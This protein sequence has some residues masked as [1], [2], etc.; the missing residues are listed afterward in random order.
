M[1]SNVATV[2]QDPGDELL[3]ACSAGSLDQVQTLLSGPSMIKT[4]LSYQKRP[5]HD[6]YELMRS[7]LNLQVMLERAARS[8]HASTVEYVLAFGHQHNVPYDTLI[9]RDA[10]VAA[11]NSNNVDVLRKFV[12]VMP[13]CVNFDMSLSGDPLCQ[14]VMGSR[15]MPLYRNDRLEIVAFLLDHG[16]DPNKRCPQ[17]NGPGHHLWLA[18]WFGPLVITNLLLQHGAQV[19]QSGAI[20]KAAEKG[21]INVLEAL[22]KHGANLDERLDPDVGFI[23]H[24]P[25]R[26]QEASET[27][28][29][30]AVAH[31]QIDVAAW[32]LER[33]VDADVRGARGRTPFDIAS[34][35]GNETLQDVFKRHFANKAEGA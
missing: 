29:H 22:L 2:Q 12:A 4:A 23:G 13:E 7:F 24:G 32:L 34:S 14:A 17:H 31:G 28:L 26:Q 33:G 8:G 16:A 10:I 6:D 3:T 19:A 9:T 27:P 5:Y 11:L 1:S 25:E 35:S 15:N 30:V 21:R 18:A 20:H